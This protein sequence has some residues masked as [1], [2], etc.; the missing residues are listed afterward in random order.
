MAADLTALWRSAAK[1]LLVGRIGAKALA[2]RAMEIYGAAGMH[3]FAWP[4]QLVRAAVSTVEFGN[5]PAAAA[6]APFAPSGSV[7]SSGGGGR[8]R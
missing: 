7:L 6:T 4:E 1:P 5:Q 2:P 3:V 8:P